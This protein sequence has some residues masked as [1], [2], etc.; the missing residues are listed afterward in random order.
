MSGK[1]VWV[2]L[3]IELAYV[4]ISLNASRGMAER[5][6]ARMTLAREELR[7]IAGLSVADEIEKLGRLKAI[8]INRRER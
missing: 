7:H 5:D 8:W 1:L 6:R 3:L 4:G 2:V